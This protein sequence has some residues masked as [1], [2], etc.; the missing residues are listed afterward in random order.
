MLIL[1]A[2]NIT[3]AKW[4]SYFVIFFSVSL[5][6]K[7]HICLIKLHRE[8]IFIILKVTDIIQIANSKATC[9]SCDI[10][11]R[12]RWKR[13]LDWF[14]NKISLR[15]SNH[16]NVLIPPPHHKLHYPLAPGHD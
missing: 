5:N 15:S 14:K 2:S 11:V 7:V 8:S 13:I 6:F 10:M 12:R 1:L 16:P 9:Y 4:F 3:I